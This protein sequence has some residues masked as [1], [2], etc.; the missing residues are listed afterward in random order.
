MNLL[1]PDSEEIAAG[2]DGRLSAGETGELETHLADCDPCR[3]EMTLLRLCAREPLTLLPSGL[4]EK[5]LATP[6]PRRTARRSRR[7]MRP[8]PG[9]RVSVR[10]A[11]AAAGLL[12]TALLGFL[13]IPRTGN[14]SQEP[15]EPVV[16]APEENPTPGSVP[17]RDED[18]GNEMAETPVPE[19]PPQVPE[20]KIAP[21]KPEPLSEPGEKPPV[22]RSTRE[23]RTSPPTEERAIVR[24]F[25]SLALL[26]PT[27][28]LSLRR[29]GQVK[30]VRIRGII[31]VSKG[32]V[33]RAESPSAFL[34][35]G[36]HAV[37]LA[38]KTELTLA[39]SL[40]E[41][42]TW[43]ALHSGEVLVAPDGKGRSRWTFSD[44]REGAVV[45]RE[46]GSRFAAAV[47][48]DRAALFALEDPIRLHAETGSVVTV[49]AGQEYAGGSSRTASWGIRV[50]ADLEGSL[51]TRR[52]LFFATC[53]SVDEAQ[54]RWSVEAGKI[55]EGKNPFLQ[56]EP[57]KKFH[58]VRMK[59]EQRV[60]WNLDYTIRFRCR[61]NARRVRVEVALPRGL[62]ALMTDITISRDQR[63]RWMSVELPMVRFLLAGSKKVE[64]G[65]HERMELLEF[66][67]FQKDVPGSARGFVCIDDVEILE[68]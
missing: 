68:R 9:S 52:S 3:R 12:V 61:T 16:Q 1:C 45:I 7:R 15:S 67:V 34:I 48:D 41:K 25:G 43:L 57:R 63:N 36:R 5:I 51:P 47:R 2:V 39:G 26:N 8:V 29:A 35:E 27:G 37:A 42:S 66:R 65:G 50:E 54:G 18:S 13:L 23:D 53:D 6:H 14:R 30:G 24:R 32:D 33:I 31:R 56:S 60:G 28:E 58:P 19:R 21:E 44:D 49:P 64:L 59:L 46:T 40:D 11:A 17:S 22:P 62:G 55:L 38:G 20:K 10:V 4:Q